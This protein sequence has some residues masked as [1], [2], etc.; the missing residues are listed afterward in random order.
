M[1]SKRLIIKAIVTLLAIAGLCS[2]SGGEEGGGLLEENNLRYSANIAGFDDGPNTNT[3]T[4]DVTQIVCDP[5]PPPENET[6]TDTLANINVSVSAGAPGITLD[7]YEIDYIPILSTDINDDQIM[8]PDLNDLADGFYIISIPSGGSASFPITCMR[9]DTKTY[10]FNNA[11]ATLMVARYDIRIKLVFIDEYGV[12]R[13]I[14]V[15]R[16]VFLKEYDNC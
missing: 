12:E 1:R 14:T 11:P 10:Y 8:P 15:R 4:I 2:C 5:G 6:W 9:V 7:H 3:L 16:T 13:E